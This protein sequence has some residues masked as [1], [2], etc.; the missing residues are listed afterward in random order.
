M[1]NFNYH[2]HTYRCMHSDQDMSDEEYIKDYI[3]MGFKEIA[4][5]DH[6]PEKNIIDKR[7][8]VRMKYSQ[9]IEYLQSIQDLKKKYKDKIKIKSGYEVE[10]LPGEEKNIQELKDETDILVL[11]QHFVYGNDKEL[12]ILGKCDF[13]DEE[14]LRYANCIE[15]AVELGIPDIIAHP[16]IYLSRKRKFGDIEKEVA[17]RICKIAEKYK[18]PLEINLNNIFQRTYNE[19][20]ILN[21]FPLD[22]Q[23]KKLINV[24]YPRSEFWELAS[25]YN[26]KV[27]YG[28]DAHY[29]GQIQ[30][31]NEL[32]ILA[33]EIIGEKTISKLNF[34]E[35][36]CDIN[37]EKHLNDLFSS[38]IETILKAANDKKLDKKIKKFSNF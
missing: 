8:R 11:G 24:N 30:K 28:L 36:T 5:T 20:R 10:F 32:I 15:K 27:L 34:I 35:K 19:N 14:L 7:P 2:S 38:G 9:R 26:V 13:S 33:N 18:I 23:R 16:D 17:I 29:R 21:N 25:N 12:R 22:E 1:Q 37:E 4:I 6:C 31:W 3:D